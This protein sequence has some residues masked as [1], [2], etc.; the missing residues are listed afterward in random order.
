MPTEVTC[1]VTC[2]GLVL[3]GPLLRAVW[4]SQTQAGGV[5]QGDDPLDRVVPVPQPQFRC[6][7]VNIF[8]SVCLYVWGY[9]PPP[10]SHKKI[11]QR[12]SPCEK[13]FWCIGKQSALP[14]VPSRLAAGE[15]QNAR[16][17]RNATSILPRAD[18]FN[19]RQTGPRACPGT[20]HPAED[21]MFVIAIEQRAALS[22][23]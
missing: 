13:K 11:W 12:L 21:V 22:A 1:Y 15:L 17:V 8:L 20:C 18:R 23:R 19:T 7:S 4:D 5:P 3:R 14:I 6:D 16:N 2:R 10:A 9:A